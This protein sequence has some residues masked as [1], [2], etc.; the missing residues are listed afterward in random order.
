MKSIYM[1][2]RIKYQLVKRICYKLYLNVLH[3]LEKR[4]ILYFAFLWYNSSTIFW[5]ILKRYVMLQRLWRFSKNV[6]KYWLWKTNVEIIEKNWKNID[7]RKREE[8][9][10]CLTMRHSFKKKALE[11]KIPSPSNSQEELLF[12]NF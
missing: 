6:G 1:L 11:L 3:W 9:I 4:H 12:N 8:T 7:E 10:K 5:C 2:C